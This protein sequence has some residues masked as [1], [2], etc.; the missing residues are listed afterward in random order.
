[1]KTFDSRWEEIHRERSWGKYPSEDVIRFIARNY[2]SLER[3]QVNILDFGCG[4]GANTYFIA[5]EKF[6]TYAFDGSE[7]AVKVAKDRMISENLEA[8]ILV[9][10]G[11]NTPYADEFFDCVIDSA[12]IYANKINDIKTILQEVYRI[13]KPDGKIFSTGL[14]NIKTT[15]YG[16]GEE[17]ERNTYRNVTE[18]NLMNMGTVHFFEKEEVINI[19]K[20]IGFKDLKIDIVERTDYNEVFKTSYYI[21]EARK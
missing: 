3:E 5:K 9:C 11:A 17:L 8:D 1:M 4:Q 14:F 10:D 16:T 13:L 20:E 6:N 15:G 2:Y 19:W 21:V 18:G 12:V 7:S